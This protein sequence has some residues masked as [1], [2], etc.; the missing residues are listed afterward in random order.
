MPDR[1]SYLFGSDGFLH[2]QEFLNSS[3]EDP[4][5]PQT[6]RQA[7]PQIVTAVPCLEHS[8]EHGESSQKTKNTQWIETT[9]ST[10]QKTNPL[11]NDSNTYSQQ[12]NELDHRRMAAG[13]STDA[14]VP[15]QDIRNSDVSSNLNELWISPEEQLFLANGNCFI[16]KSHYKDT[17]SLAAAPYFLS[18]TDREA[19]LSIAM[20]KGLVL[21]DG[22]LGTKKSEEAVSPID[23][24]RQSSRANKK[25][26]SITG[27]I[28]KQSQSQSQT[29]RENIF[30]SKRRD[31]NAIEKKYRNNLNDKFMQLR[32]C[33]PSLSTAASSSATM[34]ADFVSNEEDEE[35]ID[36]GGL[37]AAHKFNK[38]TIIVK[39][40]EYIKHLEEHQQKLVI[41]EGV[42]LPFENLG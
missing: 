18:D 21:S 10:R 25:R 17:G 28:I 33:V 40:I 7:S 6:S 11:D 39:A 41:D 22:G 32:R 35:E 13:F 5:S 42:S 23:Q 1:S 3:L 26:K 12:L 14:M 37:E 36:L 24:P 20:P 4:S 2:K 15:F 19:L 30:N 31:H 29:A 9:E 34:H 16:D 27:D 38:A 8:I